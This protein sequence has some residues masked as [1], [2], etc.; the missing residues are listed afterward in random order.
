MGAK[1][2]KIVCEECRHLKGAR[3]D[4]IR[5]FVKHFRCV[6]DHRETK[7]VETE[8][9]VPFHVAFSVSAEDW[10]HTRIRTMRVFEQRCNV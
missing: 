9:S 4:S 8:E 7:C 6:I 3:G 10:Y 2:E 1:I 5:Q